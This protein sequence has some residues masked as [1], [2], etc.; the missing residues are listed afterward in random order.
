M[1]VS[2]SLLSSILD[3]KLSNLPSL[4]PFGG[5]TFSGDLIGEED[6]ELDF[7]FCGDPALDPFNPEIADDLEAALELVEE[8]E[9]FREEFAD[10]FLDSDAEDDILIDVDNEADLDSLAELS[11][12]NSFADV[13]LLGGEDDLELAEDDFLD[14]PPVELLEV[15]RTEE[16]ELFLVDDVEDCP[17]LTKPRLMASS[18]AISLLVS[19]SVKM[20]VVS[21]IRPLLRASW[22]EMECSLYCS[23]EDEE[24]D[25][26]M[27]LL[28]V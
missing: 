27:V 22:N 25:T 23:V 4:D 3:S 28:T 17:I 5:E 20:P 18:R 11:L 9:L 13:K 15:F 16:T 12:R 2:S 6:F 1:N 7:D 8:T 26:L 21:S 24:G 14:E 19:G 10:M